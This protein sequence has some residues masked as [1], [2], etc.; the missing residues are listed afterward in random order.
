MAITY[1]IE[2]NSKPDKFGR[3]SV[4]IRLHLK[5]QKPARVQTMVK[6][7]NAGKNWQPK[8]WGKWIKGHPDAEALNAAILAEHDRVKKQVEAWQ[9]A[10]FTGSV[11]TPG[12]LATRFKSGTSDLYFS[13]LDQAVDD[14]KTLAYS[15]YLS[16]RTTTNMFRVFAG[17]EVP[18]LAITPRLA[19]EFQ[20]Y[21]LKLP[22]RYHAGKRKA[23]T[24]NK[25]INRMH[26]LHKAVLIKTGVSAKQADYLSPWN[27]VQPL[28]EARARK[29]KLSEATIQRVASTTVETT[30]R[31]VTPE[32][33]FHV[34]L[35]CHLLAGARVSDVLLLRY[36]DFTLD[37]DGLPIYLRYEMR[38]TGNRVNI[39]VFD[40]ARTLLKIYWND[41]ASPTDFILPYLESD[42]AYA[43]LITREQYQAAPFDVRRKLYNTLTHWNRQLNN[44]LKLLQQEAGL[45]ETIKTHNAR[46]SFADLAR[47]IMQKEKSITVYDIQLMMGHS[48]FKTTEAYYQADDQESDQPMQ[49]I[50][51][52]KK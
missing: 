23:S 36:Q 47:R 49:A 15:T 25:Y 13:W 10:E 1:N 8:K 41:D 11:L 20:N 18:L 30:R 22:E 50:F 33:A 31:K 38:K 19:R 6:I 14:T 5:D 27:D 26:V 16:N 9:A 12:I 46:H 7:T 45:K 29:T 48:N 52:R 24:I 17:E 37:P 44:C 40:E 2:L 21:L 51:N 35:L 42:Q 4:M 43:K 34:W 3:S 32:R 28:P 39:P